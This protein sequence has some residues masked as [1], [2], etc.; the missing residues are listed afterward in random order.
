[1]PSNTPETQALLPDDPRILRRLKATLDK[2]DEAAAAAT[3]GWWHRTHGVIASV[4]F[5]RTPDG[6]KIASREGFVVATTDVADVRLM[7]HEPEIKRGGAN[8]RW[9]GL[10]SPQP[11]TA[12]VADV[13]KLIAAVEARAALTENTHD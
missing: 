1:M 13:R 11:M 2:I 10:T 8:A 7:D 3:P 5:H 12:F 6:K 9:I 4:I